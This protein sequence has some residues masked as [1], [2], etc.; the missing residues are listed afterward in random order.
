[1]DGT[2]FGSATD[3][4]QSGSHQNGAVNEAFEIAVQPAPRE[5]RLG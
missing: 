2:L 5:H 1:M 4:L 3:L